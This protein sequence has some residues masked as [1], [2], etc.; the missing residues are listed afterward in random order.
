MSFPYLVCPGL[1]RR[2]ALD[3]SWNPKAGPDRGVF[4]FNPVPGIS[5]LEVGHCVAAGKTIS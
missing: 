4:S 3:G 1:S 5:G 2:M